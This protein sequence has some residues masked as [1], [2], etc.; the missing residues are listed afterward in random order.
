MKVLKLMVMILLVWISIQVIATNRPADIP[1]STSQSIKISAADGQIYDYFGSQV[2]ISGNRALIGAEMDD[3]N[4][5]RS[6]SAYIFEFDGANWVES[7]KLKPVDGGAFNYFGSA[8][9]LSGNRALIAAT[10]GGDVPGSGA[11]Y[12]FDYD[13]TH[14]IESDKFSAS[15]AANTDG[16]GYVVSLSGDRALIGKN[17][18]NLGAAYVFDF[19]GTSWTETQKLITAEGTTNDYFGTSVSIDGNR[20]LVGALFSTINDVV[21]GSVYVFEY[22][23]TTWNEVTQLSAS[24]GGDYDRFG[25][26]VELFNDVAVIGSPGNVNN[27]G[28]AYIFQF[29]GSAWIENTKLSASDG[30]ELDFFAGD[31]SF[32][33]NKLLISADGDDD[34]GQNS[35]AAY[36]FK[37]DGTNWSEADKFTAFDGMDDDRFGGSVSLSGDKVLIGSYVGDGLVTDSGAAYVFDT[38]LIFENSFESNN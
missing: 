19:D 4:G 28:A 31:L 2:S 23:E 14:W 18:P 22:N 33:D 5:D 3:D 21:T 9:A 32:V 6:G 25:A 11:V 36:L 30:E 38:D 12:V 10:Y 8:V 24:D 1:K 27:T 26:S 15:D 35:G 16:F 20:A 37:F 34:Q 17:D 29:N 7:I 13:G